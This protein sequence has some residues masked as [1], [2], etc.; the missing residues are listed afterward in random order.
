LCTQDCFL[1]KIFLEIQSNIDRII[2]VF[3]PTFIKPGVTMETAPGRA[4]PWEIDYEQAKSLGRKLGRAVKRQ[5][6]E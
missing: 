2:G 6:K 5:T 1:I 4:N 3:N